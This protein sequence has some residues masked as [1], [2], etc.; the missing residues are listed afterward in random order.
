MVEGKFVVVNVM[1][2]LMNVRSPHS[3]ET[4]LHT[5]QVV[6]LSQQCCQAAVQNLPPHIVTPGFV[7]RPRRSDCTAGQ[8]DLEV[9]W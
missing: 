5:L 8:M 6:K 9:G 7:D 4:I 2:S 3:L 1:L